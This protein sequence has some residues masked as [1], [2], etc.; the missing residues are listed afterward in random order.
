MTKWQNK[1]LILFLAKDW[2]MYVAS[3]LCAAWWLEGVISEM[4]RTD[5]NGNNSRC[6]TDAWHNNGRLL[7]LPVPNDNNLTVISVCLFIS[8]Y[9]VVLIWHQTHFVVWTN[10]G[11]LIMCFLYLWCHFNSIY[12]TK[13]YIFIF[14]IM[15]SSLKQSLAVSHHVP[16]KT[17]F[18]LSVKTNTIQQY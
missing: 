3:L 5:C 9:F 4:T 10:C 12:F 8:V 6:T 1:G 16:A 15:Y 14:R 11:A 13:S 18:P 2:Y 17:D 7:G